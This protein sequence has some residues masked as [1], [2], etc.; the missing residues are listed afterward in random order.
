MGIGMEIGCCNR[1]NLAKTPHSI[2]HHWLQ[3]EPMSVQDICIM[4]RTD[5]RATLGL[6]EAIARCVAFVEAGA[7]ITFLEAPRSEE[8]MKRY[9]QEV[10][11]LRLMALSCHFGMK[12]YCP[13]DWHMVHMLWSIPRLPQSTFAR[14]NGSR[15]RSSVISFWLYQTA[16]L[17]HQVPGYKM[18]N[19]LP[20]GKTP[21]LSHQRLH[22]LGFAIAAYPLSL[23]SAGLKAQQAALQSL[24]T[25]GSVDR[26]TSS[27]WDTLFRF[28]VG[29]LVVYTGDVHHV[30]KL[31]FK[32]ND[33]SKNIHYTLWQK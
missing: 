28:S 4:A 9:C 13:K 15:Q 2:A 25:N 32:K 10:P 30:S 22:D 6:D 16:C 24:Q 29:R 17:R 33:R 8:E 1:N 14:K 5:A 23:L 12:K 21:F 3:L 7:D 19:M 20:S 27:G 31:V 11:L 18:V 26:G